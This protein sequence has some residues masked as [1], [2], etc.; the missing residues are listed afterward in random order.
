MAGDAVKLR[1]LYP[2]GPPISHEGQPWVFGLQ[3][4]K[5][6]L[7]DGRPAEGGLTAFDFELR[8]KPGPDPDHPVFLGAFASGP[9]DGRFV[10]FAWRDTATGAWI[11]R[12]KAR[13]APITWAMV[14]DAQAKDLP[15]TATMAGRRLG[16]TSAPQ[17]RVGG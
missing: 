1:L 2:V 7:H 3:D 5:Q 8:V 9:A 13:L 11:N 15:I 17:W 6:Q 16:D 14:R 12:L 4:T 10:Y